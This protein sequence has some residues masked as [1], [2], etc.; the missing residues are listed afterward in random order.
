LRNALSVIDLQ[1]RTVTA[2]HRV[3]REPTGIALSPG[4]AFAYVPC[5]TDD[6]L[7]TVPLSQQAEIATF[8]VLRE[9]QA[10]ALSADG[11][12]AYVVQDT[13]SFSNTLRV[14]DLIT[15]TPGASLLVGGGV[16]DIALSPDERFAYLAVGFGIDVIDLQSMTLLQR[17]ASGGFP[18]NITLSPDGATAYFTERIADQLVVLDLETSSETASI[19]VGQWPTDLVVTGDGAFAY[20]TNYEDN[21]V[22]HDPGRYRPHRNRPLDR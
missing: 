12:T 19:P 16:Q 7:R 9:P 14:V 6:K 20:M 11:A 5:R 1:S 13:S 10:F 21:T 17:I 4:G 3:C 8:D 2:T 18:G 22:R 15:G